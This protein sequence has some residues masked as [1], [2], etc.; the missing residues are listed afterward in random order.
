MQTFGWT[1]EYTLNLSWPVF[2]DLTVMIRRIRY[3]NAIDSVFMP[4]SAA[5]Y[6]KSFS[7]DLFDGRGSFYLAP[8]E[9]TYTY[10]EED[11]KKADRKLKRIIREREKRLA[12]AAGV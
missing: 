10:T 12:A 11:W 5:K 1:I 7:S 2:F 6:G 9:Q 8:D 3:D 4:Y